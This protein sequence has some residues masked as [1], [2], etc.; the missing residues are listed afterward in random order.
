MKSTVIK[1]GLTLALTGALGLTTFAQTPQPAAPQQ[2]QTEGPHKGHGRGQKGFGRER[3]GFHGGG[4]R[5]LNLTDAQREQIRAIHQRYAQTYAPQ[6]EELRTIM[7]ARRAGG[8]LTAE[9]EA[10]ARELH[11]QFRAN[12]EKLHAETLA[13]LTPEQREQLKQLHEQRQQRRE[14]RRKGRFGTPAAPPTIN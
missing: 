14:E 10:R 7:Q 12:G 4:L 3:R 1:T 6:R 5:Q 13:V 11:E 2:P 8:T 9:Q